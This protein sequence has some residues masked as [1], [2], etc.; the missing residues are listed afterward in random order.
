MSIK[1]KALQIIEY[2]SLSAI[3]EFSHVA[4]EECQNPHEDWEECLNK[5]YDELLARG[6]I[7]SEKEN[8]VSELVRCKDCV[9]YRP[10]F[11]GYRERQNY[12]DYLDK[13]AVDDVYPPPDFACIEGKRER[14]E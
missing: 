5:I 13:Y 3:Y 9:H 10:C 1:D 2:I 12:C 14:G 8:Q 4:N 6:E 11:V 7:R